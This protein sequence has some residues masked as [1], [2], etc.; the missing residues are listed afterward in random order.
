[1]NLDQHARNRVLRVSRDSLV[2]GLFGEDDVRVYG[3][4]DGLLAVE[5]VK[6]HRSVAIDG[7]GRVWFSMMRGLSM[8]DPSAIEAWTMPAV[9]RVEDLSADGTSINL[10]GSPTIPS[11]PRRVTV[12]FAGLSLGVPER[13]AGPA[14]ASMTS[15]PIGALRLPNDRRRTRTSVPD[16][17]GSA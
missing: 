12:S 10:S 17:I 8:V 1:M 2:H 5:G 9:T 7:R 16:R 15:T 13:V 14:T 3:I 6:R 11:G 4:A